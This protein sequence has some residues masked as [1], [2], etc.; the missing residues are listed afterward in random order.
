[1]SKHAAETAHVANDGMKRSDMDKTHGAATSFGRNRIDTSDSDE[2]TCSKLEAME[3]FSEDDSKSSHEENNSSHEENSSMLQCSVCEPIPPTLKVPPLLCLTRGEQDVE[4][5]WCESNSEKVLGH[6]KDHMQALAQHCLTAVQAPQTT[7]LRVLSL[8]DGSVNHKTMVPTSVLLSHA[9]A[10]LG[11]DALPPGLE[12]VKIF[13][14]DVGNSSKNVLQ[15]EQ[16]QT[17]SSSL[18]PWLEQKHVYLDN[19]K[20]FKPQLE[21]P[22]VSAV[23]EV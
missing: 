13:G 23:A 17:T 1:M 10:S 12:H 3:Q 6:L 4:G 21:F 19:E 5:W 8:S 14:A 18:P 7:T 15:H 11:M 20:N 2:T 9:F 16:S 22:P